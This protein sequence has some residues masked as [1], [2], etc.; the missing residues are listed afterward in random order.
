MRVPC[1]LSANRRCGSGRSDC[2]MA[3]SWR[4]LRPGQIRGIEPGAPHR[5]GIQREAERC[6]RCSG[7]RCWRTAGSRCGVRRICG[8]TSTKWNISRRFIRARDHQVDHLLD[9]ARSTTRA[10]SSSVAPLSSHRRPAPAG[11]RS[12]A[13][14]A[15]ASRTLPR[16]AASGS[17]CW[18]GPARRRS[19]ARRRSRHDK[20]TC[21]HAS[22]FQRLVEA[23]SR[24]GGRSSA[25]EQ[26]VDRHAV[27][28]R[29]ASRSRTTR[30]RSRRPPDFSATHGIE[31]RRVV[32]QHDR[33]VERR[34]SGQ[35]TATTRR[36][37]DAGKGA[38][39]NGAARAAGVEKSAGSP[40]R[41]IAGF[42]PDTAA[43]RR[44]SRRQPALNRSRRAYRV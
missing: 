41:P 35:A 32:A 38:R 22:D 40:G 5:A 14:S 43:V 42:D 31:R 16:R 1:R 19:S 10:S 39:R 3:S 21:D 7:R 27:P 6:T 37:R 44:G 29:S 2:S 15:N 20:P 4:A 26:A 36:G 13:L 24:C 8:S 33:A 11:A 12:G 23:R 17:D 25:R 28:D 18:G 9:S 34:R 30:A